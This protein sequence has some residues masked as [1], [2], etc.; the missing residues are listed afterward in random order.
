MEKN[1]D[2][3]FW[4]KKGPMCVADWLN[5]KFDPKNP[6]FCLILRLFWLF[7]VIGFEMKLLYLSGSNGEKKEETTQNAIIHD[8]MICIILA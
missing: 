2:N 5:S 8:D 4:T 7:I 3:I 6:F 1:E